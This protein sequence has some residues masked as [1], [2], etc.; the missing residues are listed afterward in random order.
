VLSRKTHSKT[1]SR[2]GKNVESNGGEYFEGDKSYKVVS[3]SINVLKI[4]S[5]SF[6]TDHVG[7]RIILR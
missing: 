3:L 6:W 5:V 2:T 7:W 4:K 1:C